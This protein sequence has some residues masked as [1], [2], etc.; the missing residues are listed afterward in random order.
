MQPTN[1]HALIMTLLLILNVLMRIGIPFV[2][3][4]FLFI[5]SYGIEH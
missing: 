3:E 2:N 1:A 4:L 5:H